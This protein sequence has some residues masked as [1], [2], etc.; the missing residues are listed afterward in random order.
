LLNGIKILVAEDNLV[1]QK[2]VNYILSKER[3]TVKNAMD[4]N[5]A[6]AFLRNEHFDLVLM[7]LQ[8]PGMDG[9][10]AT[11]Y[12]RGEM[13]SNVPIIALTADM[14]ANETGEYA[15]A[16]INAYISKPFDPCI[17]CDLILNLIKEHNHHDR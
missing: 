3:A 4:G 10:E 17:L 16:G 5:E 8:M 11:K 14:F 12:I 1:N 7:D 9:L 15:G 6:V 2:I 13:N